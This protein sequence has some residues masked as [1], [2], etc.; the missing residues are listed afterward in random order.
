M[1][2]I[3][4]KIISKAEDKPRKRIY[5]CFECGSIVDNTF[6]VGKVHCA[7]CEEETTCQ[8]SYRT[9]M[10]VA[11][12]KAVRTRRLRCKNHNYKPEKR[13]TSK[14]DQKDLNLPAWS[15]PKIGFYY[16]LIALIAQ[17]F[18]KAANLV[19]LTGDR[20]DFE[21]LVAAKFPDTA[22]IVGIERNEARAQKAGESLSPAARKITTI[23]NDN[24][25]MGKFERASASLSTVFE[26]ANMIWLDFMDGFDLQHK[27][28]FET[29]LISC[30]Q[31]VMIFSITVGQRNGAGN[32]E[33]DPES[34]FLGRAGKHGWK[35]NLH[36]FM[37]Y[38][39]PGISPKFLVLTFVFTKD[40]NKSKVITPQ[41]RSLEHPRYRS[42]RPDGDIVLPDIPKLPQF[43]PDFTKALIT[44][45]GLSQTQ[46]ASEIGASRNQ[47][48]KWSNGRAVP[49][50]RFRRSLY[51]LCTGTGVQ[52]SSVM[53]QHVSTKSTNQREPAAVI[54]EYQQKLEF[55]LAGSTKAAVAKDVGVH[56]T[57][58]GRW[59]SGR[60][61]PNKRF[62]SRI[63]DLCKEKL[64]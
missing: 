44:E 26:T 24:I 53:G 63:D 6:G 16:Q 30:K 20:C 29:L 45:S 43:T 60:N 46:I 2:K 37:S 28:A 38:K 21:N 4:S 56:W 12:L 14:R 36:S 49:S 15:A 55:L 39:K 18:P 57:V 33:G 42:E 41:F 23:V 48:W 10:Q 58:P 59:L 40:S 3:I 5:T 34:W 27:T 52:E 31:P 32:I 25:A 17:F 11:G 35:G 9:T 54:R 62:R 64:K 61:A 19:T 47:V 51:D 1:S 7:I 8:S 13:K 50:P 22:S